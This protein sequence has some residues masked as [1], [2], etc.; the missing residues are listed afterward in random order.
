M[1]KRRLTVVLTVFIITWFLIQYVVI[2]R[3][4]H[5]KVEMDAM[6]KELRVLKTQLGKQYQSHQ[7]LLEKLREVSKDLSEQLFANLGNNDGIVEFQRIL[8]QNSLALAAMQMIYANDTLPVL[9]IACNRPSIKRSL[10]TLLKYRPSAE[11]F[12]IIV[13]QDCGD[14]KTAD[15]VQSYGEK[16]IHIQH[17]DLSDIPVP[18]NHKK[19]QG[20][21]KIARHYK[22]ALNQVFH[23]MKFKAVII[24]EDDLDISS[25]FFEY[26]AAS[27]EILKKDNTLWCVSAYND[28]GKTNMVADEPEM[29]YRTDFFPG[30]G[31]MLL[32]ELWLELEEKWPATFWDDWMRHPDNRKDRSCIRPEISRTFTFGKIGV[33]KGQY[34]ENHLKYIK[35]NEKFVPFTSKDL[36]YLLKEKYDEEFVKRVYSAPLLS[37]NDALKN[38]HPEHVAVRVEY[39][40]KNSFKTISKKLG[41]MDDLK[42]GV[43]RAGYRGIVS[44]L[45][46]NRRTYLSPPSFWNGYDKTWN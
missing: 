3:S 19:F 28:N 16:I 8:N 33:S 9:V 39:N 25:D 44:F 14:K 27:Y 17:P 21:Y 34:Y 4:S 35:L 43:P 15:V 30:L 36:S 22:W 41:L 5:D 20:Y 42:S 26:F 46:K 11:K 37:L 2:S 13:S 40:T 12:P 38:A 29:L 24:V 32:K 45:Y 23:D 1:K 7:E 18:K 6:N 10:D 31:W